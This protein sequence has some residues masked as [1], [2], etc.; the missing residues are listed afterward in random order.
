MSTGVSPDNLLVALV[1]M[2]HHSERVP[3]K[4]YR[5]VAGRPLYAYIME[6]LLSCPEIGQVVVDTDSPVIRD[7]VARLFPAVRLVERPEP[8]RGG[9]VPTN[10]VIRHD[11][12]LA[13]A[14]FY[15]QTHTTNPLLRAGTI[16]QAI[17]A[18]LTGFP[19]HDSLFSV[20]RYQKRLWDAG[21][22][23]VNHDPAVLIPTQDLPPLFEENSCLYLF[24]RDTFLA[25]GNRLGERPAMFVM[26][27]DEAW[28]IDDESD[29]HLAEAMLTARSAA[30]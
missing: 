22:R 30:K 7:G 28:D 4:N 1:P 14:R 11:L 21:G 15:L 29:L 26:P 8:L 12:G 13:P 3:G 18:F 5:V 24:E 16:S 10:D 27:A 6:T 17:R 25:R 20:T 9:A 2:R 23:P 19:A